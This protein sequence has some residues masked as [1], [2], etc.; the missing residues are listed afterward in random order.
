MAKDLLVGSTGF[1][2]GNLAAKHTFAQACHSSDIAQSYGTKPDLCVYAGVPAAMFLANADPEADLDVMRD[3][4]ENLRAIDP[5]QL[6]LISSIAVYPDSRECTESDLPDPFD[7]GLPAYGRNRR[8]LE[9]WVREDFPDAL[10]IRLPALYGIGL[11]KNFLYDLHTITPAMLRTEKYEELAAR[12]ELVR[13]SYRP[14]DN[15]FYKLDPAADAAALRDF[16]EHN[17]FNALAFTDSRSRY[18]F[19]DLRR[20]WRDIETALAQGLTCL[21]LTPPPVSAAAVYAAVTGRTDWVNELAKPP[22][23][24]DLRS[25]H[26][27][28]LGGADGYLCT[29]EQELDD[30]CRFMREWRD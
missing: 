17:D 9:L 25:L 19:Y 30:I 12:S 3:A 16:F 29:A 15:G 22:F 13:Q 14:A 1:V 11:K 20:L 2:G 5:K 7:S 24:Y 8:T 21:N 28:L 27:G 26:A 6:V 10:I 18:Q 23:D 4:R